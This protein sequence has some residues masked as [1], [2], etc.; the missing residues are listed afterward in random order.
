MSEKYLDLMED[1]RNTMK[2]IKDLQSELETMQS[3]LEQI[4]L[5]KES[6]AFKGTQEICEGSPPA[7][8]EPPPT[9]Q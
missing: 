1:V 9:I 2:Q 7:N 5:L 3:S 6:G 8:L 4:K